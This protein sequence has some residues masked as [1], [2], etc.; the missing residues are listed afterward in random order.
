MSESPRDPENEKGRVPKTAWG[1]YSRYTAVAFQMALIIGLAAFA[2]QKLDG[3]YRHETP[4]VTALF[5][6]G[7]VALSIYQ[8]IRQLRS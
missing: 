6:V 2:G 8:V 1:D 7:G 3:H 4:W 5:C